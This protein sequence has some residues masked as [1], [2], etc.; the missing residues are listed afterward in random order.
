MEDSNDC[1]YESADRPFFFDTHASKGFSKCVRLKAVDTLAA[2][3][4]VD[5]EKAAQIVDSVFDRCY[6]DLEPVGRRYAQ[7]LQKI[8][9]QE[10]CYRQRHI[11]GY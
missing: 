11:Y 1:F 9:A 10:R 5:Q 6:N 2:T 4:R 8:S 7:G 3:G